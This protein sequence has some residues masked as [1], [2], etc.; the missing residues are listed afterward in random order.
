MNVI[1]QNLGI[2]QFEER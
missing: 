1:T 2:L